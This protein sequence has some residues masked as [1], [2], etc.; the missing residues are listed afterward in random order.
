MDCSGTA[1]A[2]GRK[3]AWPRK[4]FEELAVPVPVP[5]AVLVVEVGERGCTK[6]AELQSKERVE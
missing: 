1:E 6:V 3:S 4:R 5:E 2:V